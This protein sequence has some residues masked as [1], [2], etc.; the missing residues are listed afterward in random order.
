MKHCFLLPYGF[1]WAGWVLLLSSLL[2]GG[3]I[4]AM[5]FDPQS[6]E[7]L[8]SLQL[9]GT[10]INNYAVIGLWLGAIFVGC[11]KERVEDEMITRIR[12]N[13]LMIGFYLQAIFIIIATFVCNSLDY[14]EVMLY[15]LVTYPLIFV[16]IY[17]WMLRSALMGMS[18][19]E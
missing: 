15:N 14:L 19:E 1:K 9:K 17:R 16:V 3:W 4:V 7:L 5:D 13:A 18:D 10:L 2:L 11:S 8:S 12:L 6:S